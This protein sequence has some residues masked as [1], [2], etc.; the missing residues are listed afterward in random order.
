MA[1]D[2]VKSKPATGRLQIRS[3]WISEKQYPF[4]YRHLKDFDGPVRGDQIDAVRDALHS[5]LVLNSLLPNLANFIN[6]HSE[7]FTKEDLLYF[8]NFE[9]NKSH[10][11]KPPTGDL[12]TVISDI[13]DEKLEKLYSRFNFPTETIH[14]MNALVHVENEKRSDEP[15]T[16]NN[17]SC[18]DHAISDKLVLPVSKEK[19]AGNHSNEITLTAMAG[20]GVIDKVETDDLKLSSG[21]DAGGQDVNAQSRPG[22]KRKRGSANPLKSLAR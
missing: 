11:P 7:E 17:N 12:R 3:F 13:L 14:N 19:E 20:N 21:N 22:V 6:S 18:D 8:L 16:E 5:G 15:T 1:N 9:A 2:H 10:K 4:V